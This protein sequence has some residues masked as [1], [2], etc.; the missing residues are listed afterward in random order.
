MPILRLR[1][2]VERVRTWLIFTQ[3]GFGSLALSSLKVSGKPA[4]WGWLVIA[5]AMAV[6]ERALNTS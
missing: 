2:S 3:E 4:F 1:R 6:P 5:R